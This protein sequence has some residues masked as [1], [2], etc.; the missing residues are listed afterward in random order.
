VQDFNVTNAIKDFD[1]GDD[2]IFDVGG[3]DDILAFSEAKIDELTF[4]AV[5]VGRESGRSS[6]RVDYEQTLNPDNPNQSSITNR[7][8]ITWQG[9]FR[10]GGRQAVEF[11]EVS[12]GSGGVDKYAMAKT[13]YQYDRKG[14]VIAG[15]EKLV[16]NDTFNAIM[17]GRTDGA[18]EFV[19]KASDD[20]TKTQQ[21]ASIAGYSAGDKIDISAYVDAYGS[22]THVL[23]VDGKSAVVTFDKITTNS[24]DFRLELA[25]QESVVGDL[26]FLY[27]TP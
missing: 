2:T 11:V 1:A 24:V 26:Q 10:E 25:F 7:G 15:S 6:L 18:E 27:G 5:K 17:V 13:E 8:D 4:S 21:K 14:Y 16:A 20:S 22:A 9:H 19:F 3:A 23:A 12:N